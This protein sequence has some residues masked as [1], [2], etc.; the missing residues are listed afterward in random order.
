[1]IY[2]IPHSHGDLGITLDVLME[3]MK[4]PNTEQPLLLLVP[5]KEP[6][7]QN[8]TKS[9]DRNPYLIVTYV[10]VSPNSTKLF[11]TKLLPTH[12]I[13]PA[14]SQPQLLKQL[15]LY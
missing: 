3:K 7:V 2:H 9:L 4:E 15:L 14:K 6:I 13:L 1:M 10:D 8:C 5:G 12:K 11:K